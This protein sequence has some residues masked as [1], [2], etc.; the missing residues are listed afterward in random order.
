[1]MLKLS[2][3]QYYDGAAWFNIAYDDTCCFLKYWKVFKLVG[4]LL[5]KF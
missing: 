3:L 5:H 1:M 4:I 2:V